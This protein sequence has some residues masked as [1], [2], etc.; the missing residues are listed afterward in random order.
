MKF[1]AAAIALVALLATTTFATEV[2]VN[3]ALSSVE[4]TSNQVEAVESAGAVE[5]DSEEIPEGAITNWNQAQAAAEKV[6][7]PTTPETVRAA[8]PE[9]N[10]QYPY[11][12]LLIANSCKMRNHFHGTREFVADEM[13]KYEH[14]THRFVGGLPRLR[15]FENLDDLKK[16]TVD[17]AS[18]TPEELFKM[19]SLLREDPTYFDPKHRTYDVVLSKQTTSE[20]I[21][22][23]MKRFGVQAGEYVSSRLFDIQETA[24]QPQVIPPKFDTDEILNSYISEQGEKYVPAVEDKDEL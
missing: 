13:P 24:D 12:L 21:I 15:F 2:E 3:S 5:A 17:A 1:Q 20:D 8:A 14:L 4:A 7:D 16:N 18:S 11:A 9:E 19:L 6:E 23:L 10:V 22:E